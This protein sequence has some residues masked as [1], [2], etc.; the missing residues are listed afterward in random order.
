M[1]ENSTFTDIVLYIGYFL[2][3]IAALAA[4][5]LPII[6][7]MD[8]P[9]SFL[10][11]GAGLV[12]LAVI[13]LIAYALSDSEV[14]PSFARNGVGETGS[15][16]IGASIITMYILLGLALLSIVFTEVSKLFR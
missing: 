5:V 7:S 9:K 4:I 10:A 11:L 6:K 1:T 3:V 12:G 14:L 15:K 13:F 16:V 2:V 8:N